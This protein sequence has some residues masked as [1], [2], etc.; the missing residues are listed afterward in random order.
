MK[1]KR[2]KDFGD[3]KIQ[4]NIDTDVLGLGVAGL[5]AHGGNNR[6]S[7]NFY[8]YYTGTRIVGLPKYELNRK[9]FELAER[10]DDIGVI[11]QFCLQVEREG[12]S[13]DYDIVDMVKSG[14]SK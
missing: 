4:E 3:E 14:K 10:N 2:F 1:I 7:Q 6:R 11:A 13:H 8:N 12:I 5:K 9:M